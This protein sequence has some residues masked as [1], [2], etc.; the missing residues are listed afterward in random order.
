MRLLRTSEVA[1]REPQPLPFRLGDTPMA[2]PWP[3]S[4]SGVQGLEAGGSPA[5][6]N[7][8]LLSQGNRYDSMICLP[9]GWVVGKRW[10][11]SAQWKRGVL[12]CVFP[13]CYI[14][15]VSGLFRLFHQ[16][17][18]KEKGWNPTGEKRQSELWIHAGQLNGEL[19]QVDT[20]QRGQGAMCS[21]QNISRLL[22]H[23]PSR[24][25]T[26]LG[27]QHLRAFYRFFLVM[28]GVM[29]ALLC[30]NNKHNL[31]HVAET[32]T[33]MSCIEISY[34]SLLVSEALNNTRLSSVTRSQG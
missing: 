11:T 10:L 13:Q 4:S 32:H 5:S 18:Q 23:H 22:L 15:A 8:M 31:Q 6:T 3:G 33:C 28:P 34:I 16:V 14:T 17:L 19:G 30:A 26:Q 27:L 1:C 20:I 25:R 21:I 24:V 7:S 2:C 29:P 12:Q 9:L